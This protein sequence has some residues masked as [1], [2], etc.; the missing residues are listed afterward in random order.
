MACPDCEVV[1]AISRN[2]G[3]L[4]LAPA[5]GHTTARLLR[6]L[7]GRDRL[8]VTR[9]ASGVLGI[10]VPPDGLAATLAAIAEHLS[11]PELESCRSVFI[12]EGQSFDAGTLARMMPLSVPVAR[13]DAAWLGD[14]L[15]ASRLTS[16]FQS[17]V[18]AAVPSEVFAY[19]ALLRG[20]DEAGEL[21]APDRLFGAARDAQFL[22]QLDRAARITAI[23]QAA[24][25]DIGVPV[26]V[27]FNP[28]AIYDPKFCLRT[29]MQAVEKVGFSPEQFVFEVVESDQ[30]RDPDH[31]MGILREYRR[32][33]FR[34]A[35]DDLGAGY[36]SLNLLNRLEPDFVK[37]DQALVHNV[38]RDPARQSIVAHVLGMARDLGCRMIAEGVEQREDYQWL[39]ELGVDFLQGYYFARPA[40]PPPRVSEG[41][42]GPPSPGGGGARIGI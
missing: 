11:L 25:H 32:H 14:L 36:A 3:R 2:P 13:A 42:H 21:V 9:S 34:V 22:F 10:D 5:L 12:E 17:I 35:L 27:N 33:G 29:T 40:S 18:H 16:H 23:E 24:R 7:D 26:F 19:E 30:V 20:V 39:A 41:A 38:A 28:T 4:Y 1:P 6:E 15:D 31:L 37:L 8:T